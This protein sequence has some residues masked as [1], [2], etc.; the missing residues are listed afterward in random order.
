MVPPAL[1]GSPEMSDD[2]SISVTY[3]DISE[4]QDNYD[5][6]G[7]L[8]EEASE[9][10]EIVYLTKWEGYPVTRST[11][12]P[13]TSFGD[14]EAALREWEDQK[15]RVSRGYAKPFDVEKL[16]A[17]IAAIE[18]AQQ[19]RRA[20]R[21]AK[22]IRKGLSV[23]PSRSASEERHETGEAEESAEEALESPPRKSSWREQPH[24]T[25]FIND[26]VDDRVLSDGGEKRRQPKRRRQARSSEN[27]DAGLSDDSLVEEIKQ[28]ENKK[29]LKTRKAT[30]KPRREPQATADT[31]RP[32]R[33]RV[34]PPTTASIPG[35]EKVST[36]IYNGTTAR[37]TGPSRGARIGAVGRGPS[38]L[39]KQ[40]P[41]KGR[42][43]VHG[44]AIFRSW[45]APRKARS[46]PAV[47]L[48][49]SSGPSNP[50][51]YNKLS[52][53][54]KLEKA[55]RNEPAPNPDQIVLYNLKDGGKIVPKTVP[56]QSGNKVPAKTPHQLIME[57]Q[58]QTAGNKLDV[59][60]SKAIGG[61]EPTA[62]VGLVSV[63]SGAEGPN[64]RTDQ[65]TRQQAESSVKNNV[66]DKPLEPS[67]ASDPIEP[68]T[69]ELSSAI[70][71]PTR[72]DNSSPPDNHQP[73]K[74]RSIP[75]TAYAQRR[76][77]AQQT[78]YSSNSA[79]PTEPNYYRASQTSTPTTRNM[80]NWNSKLLW[81]D[82]HG[83]LSA[84]IAFGQSVGGVATV[85]IHGL[86][87]DTEQLLS[88]NLD[89]SGLH[90]DQM[91]T[92]EDYRTHFMGVSRIYNS[93]RNYTAPRRV[94]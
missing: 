34:I 67:I 79:Q 56:V 31:P 81:N 87:H 18:E 50:R 75:F 43:K 46:R 44:A 68:V 9:D 66:S 59:Q 76:P 65:S 83:G 37:G 94:Y 72:A 90:F 29:I 92:P 39:T 82:E 89:W 40:P 24:T 63:S 73:T 12:E 20:R 61:S 2:D 16:E 60:S 32:P 30:V 41:Q 85:S 93:S 7:I 58:A 54:R 49:V 55:S 1:P 14:P 13:I 23:S 71:S 17:E 70:C 45:D 8:A 26:D 11:W 53:R 86:G 88:D 19:D 35:K 6:E 69:A 91:V 78:S 3:S 38:R 74:T 28:K 52:M 62:G 47:E 77:T 51:A 48:G 5:Y 4:R 80:G 57:Q 84:V 64:L 10:G 42:A 25:G 33:P 36:K 21:R 15:M 22:R 27:R